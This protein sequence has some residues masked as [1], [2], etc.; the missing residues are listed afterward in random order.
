MRATANDDRDSAVN[1]LSVS[2][3][4]NTAVFLRRL[5]HH[6]IASQLRSGSI[7]NRFIWMLMLNMCQITLYSGCCRNLFSFV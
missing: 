4:S 7:D 5:C 1:T 2:L 3:P 6:R